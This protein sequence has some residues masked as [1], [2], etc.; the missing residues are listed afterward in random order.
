[1]PYSGP[2][3]ICSDHAGY[4]LK[5]RLL[6]F[7]KNELKIKVV[8]CGP[9]SYTKDDDFPDFVIPA[10][11]KTVKNNGRLIACCGSGAGEV[12]AGNKVPGMHMT[13]G[14]N[15]EAAELAV[16]H[17]NANGLALAARVLTD[18]HAMAIVK[19][20]LETTTMMG[21]KYARRRKKI[22]VYETKIKRLKD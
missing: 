1:M 7:F 21:G 8:D 6:R 2:L 16:K 3:Y 14:Y 22:E 5:R 20:Y 4:Q 12:I 17:N 13:I 19:K 9:K 10:A 15:I 11:E 18:E